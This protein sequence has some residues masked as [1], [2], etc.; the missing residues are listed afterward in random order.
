MPLEIMIGGNV[1]PFWLVELP[2]VIFRSAITSE[3]FDSTPLS[4][5]PVI[6]FEER[7]TISLATKGESS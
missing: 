7:K 2:F 6:P 3:S 1:S 4:T 5:R